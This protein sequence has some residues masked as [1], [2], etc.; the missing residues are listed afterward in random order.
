MPDA[1][2]HYSG[3]AV[4][5]LSAALVL[6]ALFADRAR[7]RKR[8]RKCWYDLAPLGEPPTTCPECGTTHTKP[9]H[10]TRTRRRR[11]LAALGLFVMIVGGYGLWTT[12][13]V[14]ERG[15]YGAVPTTGLILAAPWL[16]R[17]PMP[18]NAKLQDPTNESY[19]FVLRAHE[20][21]RVMNDNPVS[22]AEELEIR[23][24]NYSG[25]GPHRRPQLSDKVKWIGIKWWGIFGQLR[26]LGKL[27]NDPSHYMF[28]TQLGLPAILA[29]SEI[30]FDS[31]PRSETKTVAGAMLLT[32]KPP[33]WKNSQ[34]SFTID[35]GAVAE[36][37]YFPYKSKITATLLVPPNDQGP[38]ELRL[39]TRSGYVADLQ[40]SHLHY[41]IRRRWS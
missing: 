41:Q 2:W 1:L 18:S 23:W 30:G 24:K 8:C 36:Q 35:P 3:Y 9:K 33:V 14:I 38:K 37:L 40:R 12:P 5:A 7:G 22:L 13:R 11:R 34:Y 21:D 15:W 39:S 17:A 29:S 20:K 4:A 25:R 28:G 31:L 10:L 16:P 27:P 26:D 6:W 19:G 32:Q